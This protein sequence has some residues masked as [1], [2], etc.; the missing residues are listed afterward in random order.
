MYNKTTFIN[1]TDY[2]ELVVLCGISSI[3]RKV[4]NYAQKY[5][6]A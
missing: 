5:A 3:M 4:T 1:K 2:A 6:R